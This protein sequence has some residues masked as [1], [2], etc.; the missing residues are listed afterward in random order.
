MNEDETG[1]EGPTGL[2][3]R[4][5]DGRWRS[6]WLILN[7]AQT[8]AES[9]TDLPFDWWV[10]GPFRSKMK[11]KFRLNVVPRL[12]MQEAVTPLPINLHLFNFQCFSMGCL[13]GRFICVRSDVMNVTCL[14]S[15]LVARDEV[16]NGTQRGSK[17]FNLYAPCALYIRTGV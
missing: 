3:Y 9:P 10:S 2:F 5:P 1:A 8:G 14:V 4:S 7:R 12:R 17:Y 16:K 13:M 11:L 15:C 6:N